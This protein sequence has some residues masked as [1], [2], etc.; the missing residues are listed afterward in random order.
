MKLNLILESIIAKHISDVFDKIIDDSFAHATGAIP[1]YE[2]DEDGIYMNNPK[3]YAEDLLSVFYKRLMLLCRN[4]LNVDVR[5]IVL[6]RLQG[7]V[8]RKYPDIIW[9]TSLLHQTLIDMI[10]DDWLEL[11]RAKQ[12]IHEVLV[13]E[14]T[15]V[16][17]LKKDT[18][19]RP[20]TGRYFERHEEI[21]AFTSGWYKQANKALGNKF[22][23]KRFLEVMYDIFSNYTDNQDETSNMFDRLTPKTRKKYMK[24]LYKVLVSNH[25]ENFIQ[26]YKIGDTVFVYDEFNPEYVPIKCVIKGVA[27]DT[28]TVSMI[29]DDDLTFE[30][31][32]YRISKQ[33]S[34][35]MSRIN[36]THTHCD[37]RN[38][39][40]YISDFMNSD[41]EQ[42]K[43]RE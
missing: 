32:K 22:D 35:R 34:K 28:Y 17:Q 9:I 12:E 26:Q 25:S 13:H 20:N 16:R 36:S 7:V 2:N 27:D 41:K 21:D 38:L 43:Y 37:M 18:K 39:D 3:N 14:Y 10:V 1:S 6:D 29:S 5:Y 40:D 31:E 42:F 19:L 24:K 11:D 15:H 33:F 30:V 8:H 23:A 4:R